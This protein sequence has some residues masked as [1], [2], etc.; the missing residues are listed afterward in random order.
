MESGIKL[1]ESALHNAKTRTP[2]LLFE[3]LKQYGTVSYYD[4]FLQDLLEFID[5]GCNGFLSTI[6][7]VIAS[8]KEQFVQRQM[9]E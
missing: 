1:L 8:Y 6:S 5:C 7:L 2:T 9:A 4:F 3:A